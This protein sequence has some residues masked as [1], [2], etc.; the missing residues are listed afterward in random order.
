VGWKFVLADFGFWE[1][2]K[3]T[4]RELIAIATRSKM[5]SCEKPLKVS[6]IENLAVCIRDLAGKK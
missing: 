3:E 2:Q 6:R 4:D 5:P 1:V